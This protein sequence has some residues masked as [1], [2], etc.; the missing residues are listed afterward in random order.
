MELGSG[1][2]EVDAGIVELGS[3]PSDEEREE[4]TDDERAE[5][6]LRSGSVVVIQSSQLL[7]EDVEEATAVVLIFVVT[8][9][10]SVTVVTPEVTVT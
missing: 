7:C 10:V 6:E 3:G 9:S 1:S 5:V 4:L 8:F 2:G